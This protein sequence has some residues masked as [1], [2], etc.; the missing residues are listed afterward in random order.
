MVS[1]TAPPGA[2]DTPDT[3]FGRYMD[4][5][6]NEL[7]MTWDDVAAASGLSRQT[8]YDIRKGN[9]SYSRMR[10]STKRKIEQ[11]LQWQRGD[12][13]AAILRGERPAEADYLPDVE[14]GYGSLRSQSTLDLEPDLPFEAWPTELQAKYAVLDKKVKDLGLPGLTPKLFWIMQDQARI[15]QWLAQE[16]ARP[17]VF[18]SDNRR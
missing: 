6:R 5:R 10:S 4:D 18:S 8:L 13:D 11:A 14:T 3:E 9:T 12:V 7:D 2:E 15:E 16:P 1:M 17:D